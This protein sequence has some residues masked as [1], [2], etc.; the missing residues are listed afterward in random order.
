MFPRLAFW[1]ALF[2]TN[3]RAVTA[4]RGSFVL[5]M[6][7]MA[8]NNAT[9][10]VFWVVLFGRVGTLRGWDL[11]DVL[12]VFGVSASGFGGMQ[13]VAGGA[14]HLSRFIDEG[15]LEPLLTQPKPTLL[16]ALGCRSQASGFGDL[17]SG[18]A[19]MAMSGHLSRA[20]APRVA[21]CVLASELAFTATCV[22]LFSLAFWAKRSE[23]LSRQLL[24]IVITFSL[25]PEP[26]FGGF[27]RF[28]LFTVLPAGFVS[29][30]PARIAKSGSLSGALALAA[31]SALLLG[32]A[33]RLFAAGLRRYSSGSRFGTFG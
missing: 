32:L 24:D 15:A 21:L 6:T 10:F 7:F 22:A 31:V 11:G 13:A 9:F 5:S 4:L 30:L 16:Y 1:W 3:L 26:L 33:A 20:A 23:S 28:L 27:L 25:Y 19:F 29:F 2:R 17:A 18:L 14:V 12:L 8:L